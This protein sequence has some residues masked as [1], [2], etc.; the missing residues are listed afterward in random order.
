MKNKITCLLAGAALFGATANAEIV[1]AE[2][3]SASGYIDIVSADGDISGDNGRTTTTNEFELG[4]SFTPAESAY[5]AVAEISYNGTA[6]NFETVT[7]SYQY[8]DALSFTAGHILSYQGLESFDA[9]NNY[10]VSYAGRD[11]DALYSADYADGV[12]ADYSAGDIAFGVWAGDAGGDD[13]DLEYFLGYTGIENLSLGVALADNNDNS[14]TVN[15]MATYQYDAFTLMVESVDHE[16]I[17]DDALG[18]L[19]AEIVSATAA[20]AMGDT[21]FAVRFADGDYIT[22]D[23]GADYT[24]VSYSV[25]QALSDNASIGVEYSDQEIEGFADTD[26]FAVEL[27]YVF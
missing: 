6:A 23:V 21:T 7:V 24:K 1:L 19:G 16:D 9:P 11:G 17:V 10:F 15:L 2:G 12:S 26:E 3:L 5:S 27:L 13:L 25:F 18:L 20:Y 14:A 22:N 4:L 8:S